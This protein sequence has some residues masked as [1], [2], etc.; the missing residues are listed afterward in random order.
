MGDAARFQRLRQ[1]A[2]DASNACGTTLAGSVGGDGGGSSHL[3]S[4]RALGAQV[5]AAARVRSGLGLRVR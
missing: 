4:L 2:A 1:L 3:N 5:G